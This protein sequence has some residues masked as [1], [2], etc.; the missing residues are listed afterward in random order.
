MWLH[1][2]K[3]CNTCTCTHARKLNPSGAEGWNP[4][5]SPK[6]PE[7]QNLKYLWTSTQTLVLSSD[8]QE[9]SRE[10]FFLL[11]QLVTIDD[12][13]IKLTGEEFTFLMKN[14][15][16]GTKLSFPLGFTV[17][18]G[19]YT[20]RSYRHR[21]TSSLINRP[22][23]NAHGGF[24]ISNTCIQHLQITSQSKS[25]WCQEINY[26]LQESQTNSSQK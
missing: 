25:C 24:H 10:L 22:L 6:I 2:D 18:G 13:T 20:A 15:V 8:S 21:E 11:M 12:T 9:R 5:W 14:K 3:H 16:N 4:I 26:I 19:V 7:L 1:A 23:I 17:R